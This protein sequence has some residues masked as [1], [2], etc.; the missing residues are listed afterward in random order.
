MR[1]DGLPNGRTDGQAGRQA[2]R[3]KER[4][5]GRQAGRQTDMTKLL[6]PF[7]SF[8]YAHKKLIITEL[9]SFSS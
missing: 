3:P 2:G 4:Q 8:V 9:F 5:T 1:A 6:D 7:S